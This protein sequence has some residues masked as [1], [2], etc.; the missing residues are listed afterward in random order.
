MVAK[1][2]IDLRLGHEATADDLRGFDA[3][4]I[5]TG[6][7]PRDPGIPGQ[8]GPNVPGYAEALRGAPAGQRVAV[9]GAGGIGFDVAEL[10]VHQGRSPTLN[11]ALWHR[12]WGV[13]DPATSPGGLADGGP[14]PGPPARKVMLLQRKAEKPGR[15]LGKTTGWSHRARLQARGVEML[16]GYCLQPQC[17]RRAGGDRGCRTAPHS[18]RYGGA[19]HRAGTPVG[20]CRGAGGSRD[21]ASCYR[22]CR[23]GGRT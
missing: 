1:A 3:V 2:G 6:I 19:L 22:G 12:E 7:L 21:C 8:D 20:P 15:R 23:I 17:P 14:R 4:V 18:R 10:L 13:G 9:I 16:G 5:A 11:P